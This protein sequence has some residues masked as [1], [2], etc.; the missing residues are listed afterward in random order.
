MLENNY[1]V[2][3]KIH[4]DIAIKHIK[5][6]LEFFKEFLIADFE[7]YCNIAKQISTGLEIKIDFKDDHIFI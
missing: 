4:I 6:L 7:N 5:E 3:K 1:K 2:K